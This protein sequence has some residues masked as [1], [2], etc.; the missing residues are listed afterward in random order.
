MSDSPMEYRAVRLGPPLDRWVRCVWWARA[1]E[2]PA[3]RPAE[4]IVPDGCLEIVIHLGDPFARLTDDGGSHVQRPAVLAGQQLRAIR[5][6]PQG[7][8]F[9]FG[10]RFEPGAAAACLGSSASGFTGH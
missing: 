1:L 7:R 8:V 3:E 10:I 6:R 9:L 5:V 4:R 2:L